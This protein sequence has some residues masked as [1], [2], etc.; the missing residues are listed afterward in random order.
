VNTRLGA[1]SVRAPL[2]Q[3]LRRLGLLLVLLGGLEC[4]CPIDLIARPA[5]GDAITMCNDRYVAEV[6][7]GFEL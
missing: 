6:W 4:C 7:D 1:V 5:L 2:P 3:K